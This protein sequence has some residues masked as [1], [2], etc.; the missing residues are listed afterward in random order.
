MQ[1][2]RIFDKFRQSKFENERMQLLI[3]DRLLYENMSGQAKQTALKFQESHIA[4]EALRQ[5][6]EV[7]TQYIADSNKNRRGEEK[8]KLS[9]VS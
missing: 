4:K 3:T 7:I 9:I 2:S 8:W 1:C 5:Y 6:N